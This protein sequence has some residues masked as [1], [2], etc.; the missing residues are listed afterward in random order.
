MFEE[1]VIIM[2]KVAVL[3]RVYGDGDG[4]A[5]KE[6]IAICK[7]IKTAKEISLAFMQDLRN[8]WIEEFNSEERRL[9]Y[10]KDQEE[11][12]SSRME[13]THESMCEE[14]NYILVVDYTDENLIVPDYDWCGYQCFGGFIIEIRWVL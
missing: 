11:Y 9:T 1:R 14:N 5:T 6:L 10:A 8:G 2:D 7:T 13:L 12:I 3:S 4:T